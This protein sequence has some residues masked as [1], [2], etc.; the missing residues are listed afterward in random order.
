MTEERNPLRDQM[1]KNIIGQH[2]G[3]P[4]TVEHL[5]QFLPP[6][7]DLGDDDLQPYQQAAVSG[8]PPD[9]EKR[10]LDPAT[11]YEAQ[12]S[13]KQAAATQEAIEAAT[14]RRIAADQVLANRR[15]ELL[16]AQDA[17]RVARDRL[18]TSIMTFQKGFPPMTPEQLRRAH[19]QEQTEIRQAIKDGRLN[20]RKNTG[21]GKSMVDRQA[22]YGRGG[23]P[24]HG[25]YRRGAFPS[26]AYGA[27][28]YDPRRGPVVKPPITIES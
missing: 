10:V 22:F 3:E 1:V 17:E 4:V 19:V 6:D 7:F 27:P 2:P 18:A 8:G 9:T 16:A 23:N 14:Q 25:N 5:A 21:H 15:V 24:A 20:P 13:P 28:N 12:M 26:Q 11:V